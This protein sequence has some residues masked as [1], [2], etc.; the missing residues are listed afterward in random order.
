M[1]P[2]RVVLMMVAAFTMGWI[3]RGRSL[4]TS[5]GSW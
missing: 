5:N 2:W 3:I 4:V 1:K